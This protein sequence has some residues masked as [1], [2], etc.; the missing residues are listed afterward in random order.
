MNVADAHSGTVEVLGGVLSYD[1][2]GHGTPLVLIHAGVADRR[3]WDREILSYPRRYRVVRYDLRGFGR[4]TPAHGPFSPA[5][6]LR[7]L[8]DELGFDR[9]DILGA[10]IGGLV[11]LDFA[12]EFP[13][14]V[15]RLVLAGSGLGL[16]RPSEETPVQQRFHELEEIFRAQEVDWKASRPQAV[17]ESLLKT[18]G[19]GLGGPERAHMAHLMHANLEEIVTERTGQHASG[20]LT[21]EH[22]GEVRTPALLVLGTRDQGA[23]RWAA[24]KVA[25]MLPDCRCLD[26]LG[27]DHFPSLSRSDEFDSAVQNF[28][29]R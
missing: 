10:S 12:Y 23:V 3:M 2:I 5:E 7:E 18:F 13:T 11:A 16:V 4:S 20:R 9:V 28:L 25:E 19:G 17:I 29:A 15:H 26:L 27:A 14:R 1:I 24:R 22:L 6:D 8:L 21:E